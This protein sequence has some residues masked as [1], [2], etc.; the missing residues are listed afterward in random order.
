M[1]D[2]CQLLLFLYLHGPYTSLLHVNRH[3]DQDDLDYIEWVWV[4]FS[5]VSMGLYI[6]LN[7][8]HIWSPAPVLSFSRAWLVATPYDGTT[9]LLPFFCTYIYRTEAFLLLL[10]SC[11]DVVVASMMSRDLRPTPNVSI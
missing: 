8:S 4:G 3:D 5:L 7:C 6:V 11:C 1:N 10:L 9:G 2:G